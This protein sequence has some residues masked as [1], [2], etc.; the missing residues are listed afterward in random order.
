MRKFTLMLALA[1]LVAVP[2]LQSQT[3]VT[4]GD[5]SVFFSETFGWEN[6]NDPKGWTAPTGF[7][8]YDP[9]DNGFNWEWMPNDSINDYKWTRE[10][11]MLSTTAANGWIILFL[12]RY[13]LPQPDNRIPV[14]N[15]VCFPAIDCSSHGS[16]VVSY[17]TCF[18]NYDDNPNYDMLLEV[19]VDN[20]VHAAA[21]DASFGA[22]WKQRPLLQP[23][24]IPVL[25]QANI[26]E[27][28]AGQPNVLMRLSWK[29]GTLYFWEVDDF[30]VSE[31]WDND[32]QIKYAQAEWFDGDDGTRLTPF[33]SIPKSQ[34]AG[35]YITNFEGSGINFG[36][37]DQEEAFFEVDI[38]KN[39]ASV[40]HAEGPKK[41]IFTLVIDTTIITE[42]YTPTEFGHYKITYDY[43]SSATDATPGNNKKENYFNVSDSVYSHAD[44]T[45]E[46]AYNWGAYK[47][48]STALENQVYAVK[49][50]IF[51]DCEAS[52]VS[53]LF[54]G[55]LADG[56]IDF[57]ATIYKVDP[58][59]VELPFELITSDQHD[60]D[61]TM[62][63]EWRTYPLN[64][65]GETEFLK[66]G[67][68]LYVGFEYNNAHTEYLIQRYDNI[69]PGSDQSMRILDQVTYIREIPDSWGAV[70]V[71]NI[72]IRLNIN[73]H[74][75]PIDGIDLS[76][77][78]A[79][80]GQNYPNPFNGRTEIGY[81]LANESEVLFTVM[82]LAGRTVMEVNQGRM[83]VGKH[84]FSLQTG[85]LEAGVY[86][87]TL[88][89]GSFTQTKQMVI[90]D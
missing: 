23:P 68:V 83:P 71:R 78:S 60:F 31:A 3:P 67:D 46:E 16:V 33:F 49:Y 4:K 13:N 21:F 40:F 65:D 81:E 44:D 34:L 6:V 90:V 85:N 62:L 38:T 52:S 82:D 54:A 45:W 61:S 5:G 25:F 74:S 69:K 48:D 88:R 2:A 75:N 53:I 39:N 70:A 89:A 55:G 64:K 79:T 41:D 20:W 87:Y 26:S 19:S 29:R 28:A 66:A 63:G 12:S 50:P 1:W 37:Y 57:H 59:A 43:K 72:L 58:T 42:T 30:K 80:L 77:S 8:M 51:S 36:E 17:E 56:R 14:N 9:N 32:L 18:M 35:N 15:S 76:P 73:D 22:N 24:G 10:P 11:P 84:T 7:Y 27:V 86:Y 47:T